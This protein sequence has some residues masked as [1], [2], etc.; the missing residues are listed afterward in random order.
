[1]K[2]IASLICLLFALALPVW[3]D[4]LTVPDTEIVAGTQFSL[5]V[6]LENSSDQLTAWE[7]LLTLPEGVSL[8]K[9]DEGYFRATLS[10]RH[11][12]ESHTLTVGRQQDG[13][14]RF[15]CYSSTN[16]ALTGTKG[17]LVT[18]T[19]QAD[20]SVKGKQLGGSISGISF[21]QKGGQKTTLNDVTFQLDATYPTL[22]LYKGTRA[23]GDANPELTYTVSGAALRGTPNIVCTA[24]ATSPVGV[25]PI[26]A[27]RG[28]IE[29]LY[30][31]VVDGELT[32]TKAPLTITATSF[33]RK[34][35]EENPEFTLSYE[36]FK[37]EETAEVLTTQPTISCEATAASVPGTYAI[38]VS[39]AE[40]VNYDITYVN[41]TLTVIAADA[42]V[43]TATSYTIEY[44]DALP[45]FAFT[46]E[47]AELEG[48]PMITCAATTSS[49]VGT[50]PIVISKGSI[51]NYND[52]YV[53]GTLTITKAPLT[54]SVGDYTRNEGETNPTF[55][56]T[57]SGFKNDETAEVLT[58]QPTVTCAAVAGSEPGT[59]P[60]VV[61]GATAQNY[62]I[63]FVNGTLTVNAVDGV[64]VTANSYTI[65]YGDALPELAYTSVGAE[66]EG[67][68]VVTCAATSSSPVGTYP[69]V[70]TQG[71]VSNYKASF[72]NGTLTITKAPLTISVGDY[73]RNKGE[74]NPEFTVTYSG[75]KND[76]TS[77]V[78]ATQP[79]VACGAT[80]D[81]EP[82]T[83][84]ITV[85]G[86]EAQNYAITYVNG[87]LTVN[88]LDIP[89]LTLTLIV[90]GNGTVTF[91]D[92]EVREKT[93]SVS[94]SEESEVSIILTPDNGYEVQY[95]RVDGERINL[96]EG[97][98]VFNLGT[99]SSS[100]TVEVS[101][102]QISSEVDVLIPLISDVSQLSSPWTEPSEGS[103]EALLD[104][105]PSTFWH[106]IWTHG[107][108]ENHTH[109][110]QVE[111][112]EGD[113]SLV[114][115]KVTRRPTDNDHITQWG[116]YGSND[117][118]AENDKWEHIADLETPY[119]E[120]GETIMSEPFDPK[121]YKYLR[122]WIDGTTTGRG[123]GHMSEFQLLG[124]GELGTEQTDNQGIVYALDVENKT[125]VIIGHTKDLKTDITIPTGVYT[126]TLTGINAGAFADIDKLN[127]ITYKDDSPFTIPD[128][129]FSEAVYAKTSLFVPYGAVETFQKTDGW[130]QFSNIS[131]IFPDSYTDDQGV[132]YTLDKQEKG[133]KVTGST[134]DLVND[135][136]LPDELFGLPVISVEGNS[137]GV[138]ETST[139][140]VSKFIR[141][142]SDDACYHLPNS[143]RVSEDNPVFDSR[144][145]S[146]VIIET[147]TNTIVKGS[148]SAVIPASIKAIGEGA[149]RGA[150]F[151]EI[152]IPEGVEFIGHDAFMSSQLTSLTLPHTVTALDGQAFDGCSSLSE[153]HLSEN[154]SSIAYA[155]FAGCSSLQSI[156][157]PRNVKEIEFWAFHHSGLKSIIVPE[158]VERIGYGAF[159]DCQELSEVVLPSALTYME[160]SVF[161][162][163]N[164]ISVITAF[165][166]SPFEM[167]DNNFTEEV[168]HN[169]VLRVPTGTK[170]HYASTA[171]WKNFQNIE[172]FEPETKLM[173]V[174]SKGGGFVQVADQIFGAGRS[175]YLVDTGSD[176]TL[177]FTATEGYMLKSVIVGNEDRTADL[178]NNQLTLTNYQNKTEVL[179]SFLP[180]N[181]SSRN[182]VPWG[183]DL[184]WVSKYQFLPTDSDAPHND[185]EGHAWMEMQYDDAQW[186]SL[187][188]PIGT[189]S[190]VS[191]DAYFYKWDKG[192]CYL[193]RHV[194][195]DKVYP[196][197]CSIE[198]KSASHFI[199]YLNGKEIYSGEGWMGMGPIPVRFSEGDNL[200]ACY[201]QRD[202]YELYFD[203]SITSYIG[204][205][206]TAVTLNEIAI[207]IA[208]G[209]K[210]T[211]KATVEPVNA[212]NQ[213]IGWS[214]DDS[215]IASV[216]NEGVVR[217]NKQGTTTIKAYAD[218]NS[219]IQAT[220]TVTV[221][222]DAATPSPYTDEQGVS[223]EL[224][225]DDTE[226]YVTSYSNAVVDADIVI[227]GTLF[228]LP[229][230]QVNS[231]S[232]GGSSIRSLVFSEG[233]VSINHNAFHD[234]KNLKELH[235]SATLT[236]VYD[237]DNPFSNCPNLGVITVAEGNPRY[238]SRGGC[239]AIIETATNTLVVGCHGTFFPNDI[240]AIGSDAFYGSSFTELVLPEGITSL[241]DISFGACSQLVS[242][243]F[244]ST[245]TNIHGEAFSEG[246]PLTGTITCY[247]EQP[248]P[249]SC[250][251][252]ETYEKALLRVPVGSAN[253]YAETEGWSRFKNIIQIGTDNH[254]MIVIHNIEREYGEEN[255]QLVYSVVGTGLIGTP[256][257]VTT[258]TADSSVG[259]YEITLLEGSVSGDNCGVTT[260]TLT[261][262]PAPL[263][264]GT[265]DVE[266]VY[267]DEMPEVTFTYS[268]F[269]NG[270]TSEILTSQPEVSCEGV[271]A[272]QY[273]LI[274]SGAEADNYTITYEPGLMTILPAT[275]TVSVGTYDRDEGHPNPV[276]TLKYEGWKYEDD[277]SVLMSVPTATC[278]ADE[279]STEGAYPIVVSGGEAQDYTFNY[280]EGTLIVGRVEYALSL[281]TD[282]RGVISYGDTQSA[283][284]TAST[285]VHLN[286][287]I[288]LIITPNDGYRISTVTLD[289]KDVTSELNGNQLSVTMDA[290]KEVH[291]T[292]EEIMHTLRLVKIGMGTMTCNGV[293]ADGTITEVTVGEAHGADLEILPN[294]GYQ[295]NS[296]MVN[297]VTIE[298]Q[299]D[300]DGYVRKHLDVKEDDMTVA[301]S[302]GEVAKQIFAQTGVTF[303]IL[304]ATKKEVAVVSGTYKGHVVIPSQ[305]IYRNETWAVT[306]ISDGAFS[307]SPSLV[308]IEVPGSITAVGN[309]LF[310][311]CS[312]LAAI[313]WRTSVALTD[314]LAGML[315]NPNL[316][317]YV[318]DTEHV[319][320]RVKNVVNLSQLTAET[321]TLTDAASSNDFYCP[322]A[323]KA[324][325]ASYRHNYNMQTGRHGQCMGWETIALPFT[326]QTVHQV[327]KDE[328]L[329][330]FID[331]DE[332]K[333]AQGTKPFWLYEYSEDGFRE[334]GTIEAGKPYLISIPNN[335]AYST[336]FQLGGTVL[337]QSQD[338]DV[339]ATTEEE[340][341]SGRGVTF[342]PCFMADE[343]LLT[344]LTLNVTND[345]VKNSIGKDDGSIFQSNL[346]APRPFE[347]YFTTTTNVKSFGVFE[348]LE[349]AIREIHMADIDRQNDAIYDLGGRKVQTM[350]KGLYIVNGQKFA[351]Q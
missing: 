234:C 331:A 119:G 51:V 263:T 275:L 48:T 124:Q 40:A 33:T 90:H 148:E 317:L 183:E 337:F 85:S 324:T 50:Y 250:F 318:D 117:P 130:K 122:F 322:I 172:E 154:L 72:V 141:S 109:Y 222:S 145:N 113:Y 62:A 41:G 251:S 79:N 258:A 115:L 4:Q 46:S 157:I 42:V 74:E 305:V 191:E 136:V 214:S 282:G 239:N 44:G 283:G 149:F 175:H 241:G 54:I 268:G 59:Y 308:S 49:P 229:V 168:Y 314:E 272:G 81:S 43:V 248:F 55:T 253:K 82:G 309:S 1:M 56:V 233:N 127:S 202:E 215:S 274:V 86:A 273:P 166:D 340:S 323:F 163:C 75:F 98:H 142:F 188:G 328:D 227:P 307:A 47:G 257:L 231:W 73:S 259:T 94:L 295:L 140:F 110:L 290:A 83:Y 255:P 193:R 144:D 58:A 297:D 238:D 29:N 310:T 287:V 13:R 80:A 30:Y 179:V 32:V 320:S 247:M 332:D 155:A 26:T 153:V 159:G 37:N 121:G 45:E 9:D 65:E 187:A 131:Y 184:P 61:S 278:A 266:K 237:G 301:V 24:T 182:V 245:L 100:S 69:I 97:S 71:T 232:F 347:A 240:R 126:C 211:L 91:G 2:K 218:E 291:A 167:D 132:I 276:F 135:I 133:Y 143:I 348:Q 209:E 52:S 249:V 300:G 350:R 329:I 304:D 198:V 219:S 128:D 243:T 345:Y 174:Y 236:N 207:A 186:P 95:V 158:N 342:H 226:Y 20:A 176:V 92:I 138:T 298:F 84:P 60:I 294:L 195:M 180:L 205:P 349:D 280:K 335:S 21:T 326:V 171:G 102:K 151:N 31:E 296:F 319:P 339:V 330:P 325:T 66:L 88:E 351:V 147:A 256:V 327:Q 170:E 260:G 203:Y 78:L 279:S 313:V 164:R 189:S 261:I 8:V 262:T 333:V 178:V 201:V 139:I 341:V 53:N 197:D 303:E 104:G 63:T 12:A 235:I 196:S 277:E 25:Y 321:L 150:R 103:I 281:G 208:G 34:Q 204:E 344:A 173:V 15:I 5:P 311:G 3:A 312:D 212:G 107:D 129:A 223:Y 28:A 220:C 39:G 161:E 292:F 112:P 7:F 111:L 285:Q 269:K 185:A 346:R 156:E 152:L 192:D 14:Y 271:H 213:G 108:V 23:Y 177:A 87:T 217:G 181:Y 134:K 206:V 299:E 315:T 169:A 76:E 216:D 242:I 221:T 93:A 38:S 302:F 254:P 118:A 190:W 160:H 293:T 27:E 264:I 116:V 120:Y 270:E 106:S 200:I 35:G 265:N 228:G 199:I 286:D 89:A 36:G 19:L 334:V 343:N 16:A 70:V 289:G 246:T 64:V 123:F 230:T 225:N 338:I 105:D 57:Y 306:S 252:D 77:E 146:N 101:F 18:L 10:E 11:D 17:V 114:Y 96:P 99:I 288:T 67:T 137:L 210:H 165:M 162:E 6:T 194:Y 336:D 125:A 22:I 244:P 224:S 267:G 284:E 68:P 316:L